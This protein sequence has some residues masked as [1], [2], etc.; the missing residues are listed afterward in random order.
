MTKI[1]FKRRAFAK[2]RWCEAGE[3]VEFNKYD[4]DYFIKAG[5]AVEVKESKA[6]AKR[7]TKEEKSSK[8]TK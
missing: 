7:T 3:P 2:E 5:K 8:K 4:A 6:A 1:A